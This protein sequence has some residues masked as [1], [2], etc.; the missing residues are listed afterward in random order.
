MLDDGK[1]FGLTPRHSFETSSRIPTRSFPHAPRRVAAVILI[2]A[3]L[4]IL[5]LQLR[6]ESETGEPKSPEVA[7]FMRVAHSPIF[8][9]SDSGFTEE[10]GT[11]GGSGSA[12][13]PFV[14]SGWTINVSWGEGIFIYGTTKSFVIRDV[15]ID[16]EDGG[17]SWDRYGVRVEGAKNGRVENCSFSGV[18]GSGVHF[19]D[20]ENVM[21]D[22]NHFTN[23]TWS[24]WARECTNVTI[25]GN[26]VTKC[27]AMGIGIGACSNCNISHNEVWDCGPDAVGFSLWGME[28]ATVYSNNASYI[29]QIGMTIDLSSHVRVTRNSVICTEYWGLQFSR[30]GN[31]T[32]ADNI[33][34]NTCYWCWLSTGGN[35][36]YYHND[37]INSSDYSRS[38]LS[39]PDEWDLGYPQGGNYW[40]NYTGS[41]DFSGPD[42]DIPGP[43]GIGDIPIVID[44]E[45]NL[46]HYPLMSR[47]A[48]LAPPNASLQTEDDTGNITT[49]FTFDAWNSTD[50]EDPVVWLDAR[51]DWQG[52]GIWDTD[53]TR[54]KTV[55]HQFQSPGQYNVT[56]QIRDD[57]GLTSTTSV[58]VTVHE[59]EIPEFNAVLPLILSIMAVFVVELQF[60]KRP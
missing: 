35:C 49:Q 55:T 1:D 54:E 56:V 58:R 40:S 21:I 14:I 36:T 59:V 47:C 46:D 9:Y 2:T 12:E 26:E 11:T 38:F 29:S 8:I 34:A 24:A 50:D 27:P 43:D 28:N 13:D 3:V 32:F 10:N 30:F 6:S 42:Q 52:D 45:H 60:R 51:W 44:D 37:F 7:G 15:L 17:F 22:G 41:D 4:M 20:C 33:V 19:R 5:F 53:W 18:A 48:P 31:S 25:V 39:A 57:D 23:C 16:S